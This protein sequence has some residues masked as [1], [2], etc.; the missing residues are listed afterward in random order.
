LTEPWF[1]DA[2]YIVIGTEQI[3]IISGGG[4]TSLTVQ[5]SVAN[6]DSLA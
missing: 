3:Q 5:R 1:A 2:E 6:T 4:T